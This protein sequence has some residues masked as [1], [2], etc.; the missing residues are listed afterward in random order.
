MSIEP[1]D[2]AVVI[3]LAVIILAALMGLTAL[4]G[5]KR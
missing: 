5:G 2:P 1:I 3:L 4:M